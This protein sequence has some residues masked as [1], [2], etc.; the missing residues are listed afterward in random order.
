MDSSLFC[1]L[2]DLL[3]PEHEF[4]PLADQVS[5]VSVI[6][7]NRN[8]QAQQLHDVLVLDFKPRKKAVEVA[9]HALERLLLVEDR[10]EVNELAEVGANEVQLLIGVEASHS[11]FLPLEG[12]FRC[13]VSDLS[14]NLSLGL[15]IGD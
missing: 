6:V 5:E 9:L 7:R 4:N 3:G 1:V 14:P 10:Q 2:P 12:L 15:G 11:A 13:Q 8:L